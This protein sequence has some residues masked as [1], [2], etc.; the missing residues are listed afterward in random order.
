M[1]LAQKI[2]HEAMLRYILL[3]FKVLIKMTFKFLSR[4][5]EC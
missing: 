2:K 3:L 4:I 5:S 1:A